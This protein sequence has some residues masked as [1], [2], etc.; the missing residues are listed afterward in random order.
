MAEI[1]RALIARVGVDLSKRVYQV[2]AVDRSGRQVLARALSVDRFYA[3]CAQLPAGCTVAME[4][5]GGA[6]HV[7]RRLGL[8][9]LD[10]RLIAGHFVTPYRM[11]GKSGKNDANDAAA[12]CEAAGR[13]HMRFVP[14]KSAQQQGQLAVHRLREGYK[15]ERTGLI[16]RIRGLLGEFGIAVAQSPE[17]LKRALPELIE[18]GAN[19][20]PGIARL[21]LQRAHL[22]WIE[23]ELQM[24]WCDERI[25]AHVRTDVR[26][27]K[28]AQLLGIGPVTASALVATV[29]DF[30]Q[31]RNARQFGAWLGLVPSQN[32]TGGKARLGRITKRGDDYLRTLLIQGAKSAVMSAGKRQ[33]RIS[34]WLVQLKERVG[35]QK[36]VVALANKNA[37]IVWAV[38]TRGLA[39]DPNH[40]PIAPHER[41]ALD[42]VAA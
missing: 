6:H 2:H 26:A 12:I 3:W 28:A 15:E 4:A 31:F 14:V 1:T 32:S 34:Q 5:C 42:A 17:A 9:G 23:I 36:A 20:L 37:R 40:V 25:A 24:A 13:P 38:L 22:H 27:D 7:A 18:D 33:D 41:A 29:D 35:W 11:A 19:E 10:A 8:M 21:G 39:F 16:N 30:S